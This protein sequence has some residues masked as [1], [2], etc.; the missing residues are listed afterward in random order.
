MA[1]VADGKWELTTDVEP[2]PPAAPAGS[3][4]IAHDT[5]PR[6]DRRST[7]SKPR[8]LFKMAGHATQFAM[9][10]V[11]EGE[12]TEQ[13]FLHAVPQWIRC[14]VQ[15]RVRTH[16]ASA[17]RV[18]PRGAHGGPTVA[19]A[20]VPQGARQ[21]PHAAALRCGFQ[22]GLPAHRSAHSPRPSRSFAMPP[23]AGVHARARAQVRA[24]PR[25]ALPPRL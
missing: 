16:C 9:A 5:A 21:P 1:Q 3:A 15:R 22:G 4:D 12:G 23:A 18:G 13:T 8:A 14:A 17:G 25:H 24:D 6:P 2:A 19:L 10:L 7:V 20:T 11:N